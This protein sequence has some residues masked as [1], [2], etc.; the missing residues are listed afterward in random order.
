MPAPAKR[1]FHYNASA[2]AYSGQFTRP[3]QQLIEVQAATALPTIGGHGNARVDNF[4]FNHFVSFKAGYTHVSGSELREG[5][6][7]YHTTLVTA[8][9]E[10]LNFLDV[11][12]ADR[13]VAR[14]SSYYLFEEEHSHYSFVGTQFDNLRIG[15]Y[16]VELELNERLFAHLGTYDKVKK[17]LDTDKEF[18]KMAEDPFQTGQKQKPGDGNTEIL[19][20]LVKD[21][22]TSAPGVRREGHAFSIHHFGKVYLAETL[23]GRCKRTLTMLRLELGSPVSGPHTLGQTIGDGE[24]WP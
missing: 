20:S 14:I 9:I 13:L 4:R 2:H 22:K 21:M 11:L 19:C 10:G 24:P 15:G 18:R 17:E 5:D 1:V 12:T 6:K 23:I 3:V 8:T 7:V 16:P